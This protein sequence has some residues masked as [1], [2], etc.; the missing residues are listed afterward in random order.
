LLMDSNSVEAFVEYRLG[1]AEKMNR[2]GRDPGIAN[3][4]LKSKDRTAFLK[5]WCWKCIT[6]PETSS[7]KL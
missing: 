6:F 7:V 5:A 1:V 4:A 3:N 2:S